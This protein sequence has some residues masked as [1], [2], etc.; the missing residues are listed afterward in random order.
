MSAAEVFDLV[1]AGDAEATA[2]LVKTF[3]PLIESFRNSQAMNSIR[4]L[5]ENLIREQM[6]ALDRFRESA[7]RDVIIRPP[8][9]VVTV[10]AADVGVVTESASVEKLPAN[11]RQATDADWARV[12]VP[13]GVAAIVF[14]VFVANGDDAEVAAIWGLAAI[15][16]V[17]LAMRERTVS[18][19]IAWLADQLKPPDE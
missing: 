12:L 10:S 19:L 13:V 8:A 9:A 2:Y 6:P 18:V 1:E 14:D 11:P 4:R 15:V 3:A 7:R 17:G 16:A 5:G